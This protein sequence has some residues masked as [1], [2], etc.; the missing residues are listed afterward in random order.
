MFFKVKTISHA[1]CFVQYSNV[2]VERGSILVFN[3]SR[4]EFE[5]IWYNIKF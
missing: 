4:M 2:K 5:L 1:F 3:A